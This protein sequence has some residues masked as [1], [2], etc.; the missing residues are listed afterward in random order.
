[1]AFS[2]V[3]Y[4]INTHMHH[5]HLGGNK[6]FPDAVH[7]VQKDEYRF[8]MCPD[9]A[10]SSRY[11]LNTDLPEKLNW[12][13]V[14]GEAEIL[15]GI[16]LIPTPGHSPGHQTIL[17]HDAPGVGPL[18][19]CGDAVYLKENYDKDIGPGICWNPPMAIASMRKLKQIAS[20]IDALYILQ[21][22]LGLFL[23]NSARCPEIFLKINEK[24]IDGPRRLASPR[25]RIEYAGS[26]S[27]RQPALAREGV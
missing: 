4:V 15:P 20:L 6:F 22:R 5:D 13:L 1:M 27:L 7:V 21:P 8:A 25:G 24:E 23:F 19:Y 11:K 9:D 17:L 12:K 2:D 10:F 14:E 3:K 18:I 16:S 26:T